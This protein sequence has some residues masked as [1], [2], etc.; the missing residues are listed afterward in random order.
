[1]GQTQN[2][3][4]KYLLG[5]YQQDGYIMFRNAVNDSMTVKG[6]E[7]ML[8]ETGQFYYVHLFQL[9]NGNFD[10]LLLLL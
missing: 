3:G 6:L 9:K 8:N 5:N 2:I 10:S 1:M 4:A 7:H